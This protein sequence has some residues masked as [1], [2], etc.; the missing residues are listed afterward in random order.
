MR[1]VVY[2]AGAIGGAI[3]GRL[4]EHGHDVVLIARGAHHDA[5][6]DRGLT[7]TSPAGTVVLPTPVVDHPDRISWQDD[8][9]VMLAMKGQDTDAALNALAETAPGVAVACAQNGVA[10]ERNALRLFVSVYAVNVMLPAAHLEPGEVLAYSA[11]TTGI[12]DLGRYPS[13]TD[14]RAEALAAALRSSTFASEVRPDIMRWKY[15]KLLMNIGNAV[16]ALCGADARAG[17]LASDARREAVSVLRTA[18]IDVASRD[19][20][21]V[22]RGDLVTM[23]DIEGRPRAGGSTWQSLERGLGSVETDYLNGEIVLLGRELGV[24]T[25]LNEVLQSTMRQAAREK[26]PPGSYTEDDLRARLERLPTPAP[27]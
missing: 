7:L 24:P 23:G 10:N 3:G 27:R 1:I 21:L 17:G 18:G 6:K 5:I 25:P 14:D 8:D 9:T 11:P 12:L 15:A 13:G 26:R 4:F 19:E 16:E 22:R 20:D 2:G